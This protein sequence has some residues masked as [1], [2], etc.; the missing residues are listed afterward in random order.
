MNNL[1]VCAIVSQEHPETLN[2]DPPATIGTAYPNQPIDE[3]EVAREAISRI[4][5]GLDIF[6]LVPKDENGD[7]KYSGY[8]LLDHMVRIR[9]LRATTD[10][11]V[12]RGGVG[13][14]EKISP[15]DY[16]DLGIHNDQLSIIQLSSEEL[17]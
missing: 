15:S 5:A 13:K 14:I 1:H 7:P 4:D 8:A 2:L 6:Q 16:L 10:D 12:L 11:K 3:V 17:R 9:G